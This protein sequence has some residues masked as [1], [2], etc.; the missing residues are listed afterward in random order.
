MPKSITKSICLRAGREASAA[1]CVT[2]GKHPVTS[3][4]HEATYYELFIYWDWHDL[5]P[6]DTYAKEWKSQRMWE[7][8]HGFVVDGKKT[9]GYPTSRE[10]WKNFRGDLERHP[11]KKE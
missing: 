11:K 9:Y 2:L 8:Q 5:G 6:D 4:A 1:L 3:A 10:T 7:H